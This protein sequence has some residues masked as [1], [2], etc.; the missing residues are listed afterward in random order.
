MQELQQG[1]EQ[2]AEEHEALQAELAAERENK[3]WLVERVFR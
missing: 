3:Q 1:Y 2:L